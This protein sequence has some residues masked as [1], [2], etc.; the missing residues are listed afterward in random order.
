[1][2][3]YSNKA[4][5]M[6]RKSDGE[7]ATS[8]QES[9]EA[10][11]AH[12]SASEG[13]RQVEGPELLQLCHQRQVDFHHRTAPN[14]NNIPTKLQIERACR[15]LRPFK[16]RGPDGLPAALYHHYPTL[17]TDLMHPLM[18][19]MAC[20]T[21]EP[22][23]FKGGKLV[24]LYKGKGHMMNQPIEE[25]F[26]FPTTWAK[27]PIAPFEASSCPFLKEGCSQCKSVAERTGPCNKEHICWGSSWTR[28]D[29]KSYHVV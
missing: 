14:G 27:W 25:A 1:M 16:A 24:H 7:Y 6:M 2:K 8:H 28:A 19:K 18:V 17:M 4:L 3:K 5:P 26:S 29:P 10:W 12:A 22:L 20:Q 11:R 21:A 13:G 15:R 23:G 9:Q